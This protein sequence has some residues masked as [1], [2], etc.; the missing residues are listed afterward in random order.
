MLVQIVV[1][2][3]WAGFHQWLYRLHCCSF[4]GLIFISGGTECVIIELLW[5]G[6]H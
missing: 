1:E 6:F 2:F 5:A 4:C 3:L